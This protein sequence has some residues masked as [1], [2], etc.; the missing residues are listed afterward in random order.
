[1]LIIKET[2]IKN[3]IEKVL[4]IERDFS[5]IDCRLIIECIKQG[6]KINKKAKN[7]DEL[8]LPMKINKNYLC[9]E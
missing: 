7:I 6:M 5:K 1:M 4:S 2:E 9:L 3:I 8:F